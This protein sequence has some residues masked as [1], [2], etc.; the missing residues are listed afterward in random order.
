M[1]I[2]RYSARFA[3]FGVS[4]ETLGWDKGKQ[5]LRY[6]ALIRDIPKEISS[7]IDVG[8]GFGDGIP[9]IMDKFPKVNYTGIDLVPDFIDY[10]RMSFPGLAFKCG[11]YFDLLHNSDAVV[12]S[13]IFNQDDGENYNEMRRLIECCRKNNVRYIS[14][15]VL[16]D[17][18]DFRTQHNHYSNVG[19]LSEIVNEYSRRYSISHKDQPFEFSLFIDLSDEFDSNTSRYVID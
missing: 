14:F 9:L 3:K 2:D 12:A 10:C 1:I 16:S 5:D 18:V 7:I 4:K 19:V 8:C 11:D 15:D 6:T 13:G 17:N